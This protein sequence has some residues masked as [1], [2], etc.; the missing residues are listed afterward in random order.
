M[1]RLSSEMPLPL[2]ERF[3]QVLNGLIVQKFVGTQKVA[4]HEIL[5]L[6]QQEKNKIVGEFLDKKSF[7]PIKL[8]DFGADCYQSL[9]QSLIQR[10]IRRKIDVKSAFA[11]SNE[12]DQLDAQLK[13]LGL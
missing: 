5:V 12:P 6:R 3:I 4:A 1:Q 8:D 11:A 2:F 9:N 7:Y 13:K 10:L